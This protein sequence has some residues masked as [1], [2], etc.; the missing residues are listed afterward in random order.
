MNE[1]FVKSTKARSASA[2]RESSVVSYL[3]KKQKGVCPVCTQT[4]FLD[5]E[6]KIVAKKAG[7][8]GA[9][10]RKR[11]IDGILVHENC[12]HAYTEEPS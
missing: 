2:L 7:T 6:L 3:T 12:A 4:L 11:T 5:E 1:V 9:D 8:F 10:G